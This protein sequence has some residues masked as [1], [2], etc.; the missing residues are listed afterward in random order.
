MSDSSI[1][2]AICSRGRSEMLRAWSGLSSAPQLHAEV[3]HEQ[4]ADDD[5]DEEVHDFQQARGRGDVEAGQTVLHARDERPPGQ[6]R[7]QPTGDHRGGLHVDV[8]ELVSATPIAAG[9][10]AAT[11]NW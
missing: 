5:A 1:E 6:Q 8:R 4:D 3:E 9:G 11:V 7:E 10:I 2:A